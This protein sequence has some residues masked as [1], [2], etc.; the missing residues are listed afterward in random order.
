ME[1]AEEKN[2]NELNKFRDPVLKKS[3]IQKF[4][5]K[6]V[7]A[8]IG[9]AIVYEVVGNQEVLDGVYPLLRGGV[10][11][12]G[13]D[14]TVLDYKGSI[15]YLSSPDPSDFIPC[16]NQKIKKILHIVKLAEDDFRIKKVLN[17]DYF[18]EVKIPKTRQIEIFDDD[19]E[20]VG[21]DEQ[22]ILGKDGNP[23]YEVVR[24]I[25]K[26]PSAI[27]QEGREAIKEG[28]EYKE[29]MARLKAKEE[30][31]FKKNFTAI[32]GYT[33][34]IFLIFA[35]MFSAD[36]MIDEFSEIRNQ[37]YED[38]KETRDYLSNGLVENLASKVTQKQAENNNPPE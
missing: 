27:V 18:K 11:D 15:K 19:G 30:N 6:K 34:L 35:V 29:K 31:W 26:K 8:R 1:K 10:K 22:P 28:N 21:Y 17:E 5:D 37:I 24:E 9:S 14:Y 3:F 12:F 20:L 36:R 16:Y 4:F 38:N 7:K 25:Y 32:A 23:E 2:N 13:G 33:V